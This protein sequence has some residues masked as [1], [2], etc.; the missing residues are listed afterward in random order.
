MPALWML[1][2]KNDEFG[3]TQIPGQPRIAWQDHLKK[4]FVKS[5]S[6]K[7]FL[8]NLDSKFKQTG[9]GYLVNLESLASFSSLCPAIWT[10]REEGGGTVLFPL[11]GSILLL[12]WA[13][14]LHGM[15]EKLTLCA[16]LLVL[17]AVGHATQ[18]P[19][20]KST[21]GM[22]NPALPTPSLPP[23]DKG[24]HTGEEHR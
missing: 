4:K 10:G 21:I 2:Q 18:L 11:C 19:A 13:L 8:Y 12:P 23:S 1:R 17:W 24:Q 22:I 3:S 5:L 6:N 16:R 20:V 9:L 7:N 14:S 15:C